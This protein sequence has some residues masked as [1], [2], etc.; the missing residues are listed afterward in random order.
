MPGQLTHTHPSH[1]AFTPAGLSPT[2]HQA[3]GGGKLTAAKPRAPGAKTLLFRALASIP[4]SQYGFRGNPSTVVTDDLADRER[5]DCQ[6][7]SVAFSSP[8]AYRIE[9]AGLGWHSRLTMS[10]SLA[11]CV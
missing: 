8:L 6:I 10:C 9:V 1:N 4:L 3:T 7:R 2:T 5:G 11:R